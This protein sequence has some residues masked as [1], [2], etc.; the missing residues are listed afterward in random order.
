MTDKPETVT[1]DENAGSGREAG[2]DRA[3]RKTG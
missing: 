1:G 3:C 2:D